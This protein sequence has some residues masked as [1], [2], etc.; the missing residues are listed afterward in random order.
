MLKSK[1]ILQIDA[2]ILAGV[3]ILLT[4]VFAGNSNILDQLKNDDSERTFYSE[5]I[6][7]PVAWIYGIGV[8]FATSAFFAVLSSIQERESYDGSQKDHSTIFNKSEFDVTS[9]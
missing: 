5:F 4:L 3:L 7:S 1:D 6:S 2:T 8:F 9:N